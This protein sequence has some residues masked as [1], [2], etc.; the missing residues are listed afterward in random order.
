MNKF[1]AFLPVAFLIGARA[2]SPSTP[3]AGMV[4]NPNGSIVSVRGVMETLLPG[5]PIAP[6]GEPVLSA[7]FHSTGGAIKTASQI[8]TTDA[9]GTTQS[10]RTAA[11]GAALWGCDS[12]DSL[13][14]M[15]ILGASSIENLNGATSVSTAA[16]GDEVV[17]L[18]L[19]DTDGLRILARSGSQLWSELVDPAK[20]TIVSQ[21]PV[22]GAKPA[23]AFEGG[24]LVT[25]DSG[26]LWTASANASPLAIAVPAPIATL[27]TAGE[28]SVAING[29]WLLN[30]T[31]KLLE[32]PTTPISHPR[33]TIAPSRGI[34]Q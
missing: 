22:P 34:R 19:S 25:T 32:I 13:A 26:L 4:L 30:R 7:S 27:Q 6:L 11:D 20:G 23:I 2:Q 29:H 5:T 1:V 16:L 14:W 8:I 18:G 3:V 15:Y 17:A 28:H 31:W 9:T 33:S 12:D 10:R 21:W 24:W